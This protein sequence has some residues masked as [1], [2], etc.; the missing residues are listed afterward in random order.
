[1][2]KII[3]GLALSVLTS[4]SLAAADPLCGEHDKLRT[5]RDNALRAKNFKQYCDALSGL[6]KLMPA[7]PPEPARLQCE[8]KANNLKVET[9]LGMRPEVISTMT[10]TF[11]QHCR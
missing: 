3:L 11:D 2:S 10:D 5:Q 1:M 9:W 8:A 7:K 4:A 6:I